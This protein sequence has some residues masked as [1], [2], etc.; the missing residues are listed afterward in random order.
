[1]RLLKQ[2]PESPYTREDFLFVRAVTAV[3]AT[4]AIVFVIGL[5]IVDRA[6]ARPFGPSEKAMY[7]LAVDYWGGKEPP[8]CDRIVLQVAEPIN[9]FP[10]YLGE[11]NQ[12]R[13]REEICV[14]NISTTVIDRNDPYIT[15]RVI[16]HE[17]GHLLG[18]GHS[19]DPADVM[20]AYLMEET[21]APFCS[22]EA[23]APYTPEIV[24][25]RN[26]A[27]VTLKRCQHL[28]TRQRPWKGTV[29]GAV[30]ADP[31]ALPRCRARARALL[32]EAQL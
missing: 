13:S 16:V 22:E 1:M 12:P 18:Y 2:H 27:S 32:T 3:L 15:C 14:S 26:R 24:E 5:A 31:K 11:S 20:Y 21:P 23:R 8:L 19:D 4:A 10:G 7:W 6:Q 28:A 25:L 30:P 9:M 29:R 17:V